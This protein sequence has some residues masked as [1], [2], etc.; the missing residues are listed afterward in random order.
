MLTPP[1]ILTLIV[2]MPCA[3]ISRAAAAEA[4]NRRRK[5]GQQTHP[6]AEKKSMTSAPK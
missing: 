1:P 6:A 2:R 3:R 4:E 5:S